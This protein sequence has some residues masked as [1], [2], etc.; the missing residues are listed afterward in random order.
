MAKAAT[1]PRTFRIAVDV[2]EPDYA[3][4]RVLAE[5]RDLSIAQLARR[6]IRRE[7]VEAAEQATA[8]VY[9]HAT[10]RARHTLADLGD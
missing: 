6:C 7:I 3:K 9:G 2:P 8:R 1:K 4:L 5:E 10:G